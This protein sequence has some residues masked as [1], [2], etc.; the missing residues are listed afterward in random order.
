MATVKLQLK[1]YRKSYKQLNKYFKQKTVFMRSFIL[2]IVNTAFDYH[3]K[4]D[5]YMHLQA[6]CE[7]ICNLKI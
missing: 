6:N 4:F 1:P 3:W 2:K 7:K 5:I